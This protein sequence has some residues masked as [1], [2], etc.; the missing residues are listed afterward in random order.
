M[1]FAKQLR[2]DPNRYNVVERLF[3]DWLL[4]FTELLQLLVHRF[5]HPVVEPGAHF[6][7]VSQLAVLLLRD[8]QRSKRRLPPALA[9]RVAYD[10]AIGCLSSLDLQP[11]SASLPDEVKAVSL[12]GHNAFEPHL[13][14]RLKELVA[15]VNNLAHPIRRIGS[16]DIFQPRTPSRER[17]IHNCTAV[18]VQTIENITNRRKLCT[19]PRNRPI[20]GLMHAVDDVFKYRLS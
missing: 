20:R 1:H 17:F 15:F 16:H 8:V 18:K 11:L 7:D 19:C 6:A 10:Q 5:Q 12:L 4:D 14:C 9:F 3:F 13:F 2:L